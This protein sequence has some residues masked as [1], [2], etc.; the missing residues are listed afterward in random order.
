[1]ELRNLGTRPV[2]GK[3]IRCDRR[4]QAEQL[5]SCPP[6]CLNRESAS[7]RPIE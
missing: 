7:I 3:P 1:M 4:V 5:E 2:I 6:I